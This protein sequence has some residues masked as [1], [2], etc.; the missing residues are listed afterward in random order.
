MQC[1]N[2]LKQIGLALHNHND[3]H[4][5][6]PELMFAGAG[7]GD[8]VDDFN[9][10]IHLLPFIEQQTAYQNFMTQLNAKDSSGN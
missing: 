7:G 9:G 8:W 6:F 10:L 1:F 2:N 5:N 3:V 4:K